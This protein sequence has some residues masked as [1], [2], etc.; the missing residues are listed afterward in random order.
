MKKL[1]ITVMLLAVATTITSGCAQP[2]TINGSKHV[3][4]KQLDFSDFTAVEVGSAFEVEISRSDTYSTAITADDNL[5][6]FIKVSQVG[7]TLK[8]HLDPIHS[9]RF[10]TL[11]AIITMPNL[12]ALRLSGAT[13]GS[14]TGF[15]SSHEFDLS[16]SGASSLDIDMETGNSSIQATGASTVKGNMKVQ[17]AEFRVSGASRVDLDGSASN[18]ELQAS[19]ASKLDLANFPFN[20]GNIK[21]SGASEATIQALAKLDADLSDASKLY[22]IGEPLIGSISV[23]GAST[24]KQKSR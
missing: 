11:K 12:Y 3:I 22:Y 13:T 9:G 7:E 16:L 4:T 1:V 23:S 24:I 20:S 5:F 21:L 6:A 10:A 17:N 15:N 18:V 8:I 2:A 14:T 19:D